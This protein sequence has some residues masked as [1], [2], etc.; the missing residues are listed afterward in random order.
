M[1]PIL[2][3]WQARHE[4]VD[5]HRQQVT[6]RP[7]HHEQLLR[8]PLQEL[9]QQRLCNQAVQGWLFTRR[10]EKGRIAIGLSRDADGHVG[11]HPALVLRNLSH[12]MDGALLSFI[13]HVSD[14]DNQLLTY[15]IGVRG[16]TRGPAQPWYCR[17]DLHEEGD[18]E[19]RGESEGGFCNHPMLHCHVGADPDERE[20]PAVRVPAVW[21][22]PGE[23]LQWLLATVH[24]ALEPEPREKARV[25]LTNP[26]SVAH[27]CKALQLEPNRLKNLV[28]EVG[29]GIFEIRERLKR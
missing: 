1:S 10:T 17:I 5:Q 18:A 29:S 11:K 2:R 14:R 19:L 28:A 8:A 22:L 21:L 27:W 12:L 26:K 9:A 7:Q 3:P 20:G 6:L 15:S 24:P 23:A 13:V 25:D 4:Q 16:V